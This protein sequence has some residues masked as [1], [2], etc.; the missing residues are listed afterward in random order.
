MNELNNSWRPSQEAYNKQNPVHRA[1]YTAARWARNA[2][3]AIVFP[4]KKVGNSLW[5]GLCGCCLGFK[6]GCVK[7]WKNITFKQS[8]IGLPEQAKT[9]EDITV[10]VI[11]NF[12][13]HLL[14]CVV[15]CRLY[16]KKQ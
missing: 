1:C 4:F 13:Y 15:H 16:A 7:G 6:D 3:R 10:P 11:N 14:K 2:G 8:Q 9:E 12:F 5:K